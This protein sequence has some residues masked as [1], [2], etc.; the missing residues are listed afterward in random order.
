MLSVDPGAER[1]FTENETNASRLFGGQNR[2]PFVKDGI[3]DYVVHGRAGAVNPARTG[4]KAAVRHRLVVPQ[5]APGPSAGASVRPTPGWCPAAS[6]A[7][8]P[9][10]P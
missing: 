8:T 10:R 3:D 5:A 1:L 7:L 2:T 6:W 9:M 4:T